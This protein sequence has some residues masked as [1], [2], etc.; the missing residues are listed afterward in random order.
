M[1][2]SAYSRPGPVRERGP[3]FLRRKNRKAFN[4]GDCETISLHVYANS[5]RNLHTNAAFG[6]R[7]G[8]PFDV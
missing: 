2:A 3:L 7:Y 1:G 4:D 8:V 6:V 5:P